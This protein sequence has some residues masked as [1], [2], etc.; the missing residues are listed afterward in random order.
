MIDKFRAFFRGISGSA[1]INMLSILLLLVWVLSLGSLANYHQFP[2]EQD[3]AS[4]INFLI[5]KLAQP[6]VIILFWRRQNYG[7]LI[8]NGFFYYILAG[9]IFAIFRRVFLDQLEY[10]RAYFP[11]YIAEIMLIALIIWIF[12]LN[13]VTANFNYTRSAKLTSIFLGVLLALVDQIHL[14]IEFSQ[15]YK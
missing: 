7:W 13:R 2:V 9:R 6:I 1:I 5:T 8:L 14:Y 11:D 12:N 15:L 10:I 4:A 3:R